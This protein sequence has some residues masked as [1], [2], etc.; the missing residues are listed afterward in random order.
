MGWPKPVGR[1]RQVGFVLEMPDSA[2]R[3]SSFVPELSG[4]NPACPF[5][6]PD[7]SLYLKPFHLFSFSLQ[8]PS[9]S[10]VLTSNG[11]RWHHSH[12]AKCI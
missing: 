8:K 10:T 6:K 5:S 9:F 2:N 1:I 4:T 12:H 3:F 7:I 11:F